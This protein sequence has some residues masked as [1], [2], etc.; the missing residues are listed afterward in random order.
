MGK[1]KNWAHKISWKYLTIWRPVLPVSP[2]AQGASF[3]IYTLN[4]FQGVLKVSSCAAAQDLILVEAEVDDRWQC[5]ISKRKRCLML[6]LDSASVCHPHKVCACVCVSVCLCLCSRRERRGSHSGYEQRHDTA[7]WILG[8]S[9]SCSQSLQFRGRNGL[10]WNEMKLESKVG[11]IRVKSQISA[12]NQPYK[13][14]IHTGV[15]GI[16]ICNKRLWVLLKL[17]IHSEA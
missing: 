16:Y 5:V 9:S 6:A 2:R 11:Q 14:K 15:W 3:L 4:S 10:G 12:P 1:C 17:F 13:I 8:T 7:H